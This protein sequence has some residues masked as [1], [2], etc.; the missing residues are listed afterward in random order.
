MSF[1]SKIL[2]F[3]GF[4]NREK[5]Y[6]IEQSLMFEP[7]DTPYLYRTPST[8]GNRRTYTWSAWVKKC[9]IQGDSSGDIKWLYSTDGSSH[10]HNLGFYRD[11]LYF[12]D[13][14]YQGAGSTCL[15]QT[16]RRFRDVA[17]WYHIMVVWDTT[18]ATA[19]NRAKIYVNGVLETSHQGTSTYPSQNYE[20]WM[21]YAD[22]KVHK[23]GSAYTYASGYAFDGYM[24]EVHHI[25]GTALTPSAFG[26]TDSATGQW[27]PKEYKTSNGAYGTN[28][29]Y[30]K[31]SN[32]YPGLVTSA[33]G[34]TITTDGDYKVHTFNSSGTFTVSTI[35]GGDAALDFLVI[36]G[37]G[38]GGYSYGG[39]GGAG[40]YRTSYGSTSGGGAVAEL[41]LAATAQAYAITVGAG[42]TGATA[43]VNPN[44]ADGGMSQIA[45]GGSALIRSEGGGGGGHYALTN[46][47]SWGGDGSDG[48]SGGGIGTTD[49]NANA[50]P[51]DP[52]AGQGYAG[53]G[54]GGNAD[55]PGG[56][57][58][59]GGAGGVGGNYSTNYGGAGGSGLS[60]SITGSAVTRAG[61]GGG[62]GYYG[63]GSGGSGGG[64]SGGRVSPQAAA[65]S[66]T[67]NTGGGGGATPWTTTVASGGSGVVI[68]RY[69][70]Q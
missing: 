3:G 70:F 14:V 54:N 66:G 55:M 2:G 50:T 65:T 30:L 36:G 21:N 60:S 57:A 5:S 68:I 48:G 17:A 27:V 29:Y 31:L 51:G 69:K 1:G 32:L 49:D 19:A 4:A 38:G 47:E 7:G 24:A 8:T 33:S 67:A 28:G 59:G 63:G 6:D 42:G 22:G 12:N 10:N 16:S 18:Q 13:Y 62:G 43:N 11:Y 45:A 41:P 56:A 9:I 53:G 44:L 15:I 52:V 64:G 25:D 58:G 35:T 40:G 23:I 20:G 39:G 61:G 37:G 34:G 46:S 26:K